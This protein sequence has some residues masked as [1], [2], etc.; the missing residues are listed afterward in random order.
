MYA[1]SFFWS[2]NI[3][4]WSDRV[5]VKLPI[6]LLPVAFFMLPGFSRRQLQ[7]YTIVA[8]F[9]FL[10]SACYSFSF[11]INSPKE[12]IEGYFVSHV[13]P[14][15]SYNDHIRYSISVALY[16]TW[17]LYIWPE[18]MSKAARWFS[19]AVM[20]FLFIFLHILAARTGLLALYILLIGYGIYS[21]WKKGKLFTLAVIGVI[22]LMLYLGIKY[23]PTLNKRIGYIQYTIEVYEKEGLTAIYSDMGR[24]ISYDIGMK[25]IKQ[26][27]ANG[28]GAGDM[29]D[30][31][32]KGYNKWY[33]G[34]DESQKLLPH[35]Q[36]L[37]VMLGCGIVAFILFLLWLFAPLYKLAKNRG[38]FFIFITWLI[39]LIPIMVEPVLEVQFGVFVYLFFLLWQ[40]HAAKHSMDRKDIQTLKTG[41]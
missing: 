4:F 25:L 19:G 15:L 38:G 36:L 41:T 9:L 24:L 16:I 3:S 1:L 6:L 2:D 40:M 34:V 29:M 11:I 26:H 21:G 28:V 12:Y 13:I 22:S 8:G 27:P 30:E 18:L 5:S 33:P 32:K 10:L 17:G 39:L 31:M 20:L 23:V 35:N 14:T 37:I 7:I